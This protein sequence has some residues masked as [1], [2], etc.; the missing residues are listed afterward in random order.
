MMKTFALAVLV[1]IASALSPVV[2]QTIGIAMIESGGSLGPV[3]TRS[4]EMVINGA[5]DTLFEAGLIGTNERPLA[6]DESAFLSF[7]PGTVSIEGFVDYVIVVFAEYR[8]TVPVPDCRYRLVRVGD[9]RVL[10]QGAVPAAKPASPREVD[11]EKAC[12]AVGSA[13]A[14]ECGIVLRGTA[15][16][17]RKHGYEEA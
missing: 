11:M 4:S 16:S 10:A 17:W 8:G 2:A 5:L 15:A 6:G 7:V 1:S 13:I 9:G 12:S 3:A 14:A